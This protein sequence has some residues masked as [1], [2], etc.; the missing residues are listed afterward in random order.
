[1]PPSNI[2]NQLPWKSHRE[3][4]KQETGLEERKLIPEQQYGCRCDRSAIDNL[5][6]GVD[7]DLLLR[8]HKAIVLSAQRYKETADLRAR[9]SW[10]KVGRGDPGKILTGI[11]IRE[12]LAHLLRKGFNR[13]RRLSMPYTLLI[14]RLTCVSQLKLRST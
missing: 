2:T 12:K 9:I 11:R 14:T 1:M 8:T 13:E 5:N 7:R 3:D 6:R 4:G 10:N